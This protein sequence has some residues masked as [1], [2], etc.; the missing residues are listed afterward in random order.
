ML[1]YAANA[2]AYWPATRI[3][4]MFDEWHQARGLDPVQ[5][6]SEFLAK[7]SE[8]E[9]TLV[10][11]ESFWQAVEANLLAHRVRMIFVADA[12]PPELQRI[13]EFLNEQ[14]TSAEVLG[15]EIKQ[16]VGPSAKTLVSHVIGLTAQAQANKTSGPAMGWDLERLASLSERA[17]SDVAEIA[18]R[19]LDFLRSNGWQ[20]VW[21]RGAIDGPSQPIFRYRSG[22]IWPMFMWTSGRIQLQYGHLVT[23]SPFD[24]LRMRIQLR[25]QLRQ[26]EGVVISDEVDTYPSFFLSVLR[27]NAALDK[28]LE[29]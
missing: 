16:Y 1:D 17:G 7:S 13:I 12:I 4:S 26:I 20:V 27:V 21:G 3:R 15:L 25:D 29:T 22:N 6:L 18:K 10:S 5:V 14:T 28:L 11:E 9:G 8:T 2:I 19:A 24:D 23:A